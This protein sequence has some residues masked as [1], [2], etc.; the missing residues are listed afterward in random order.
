[1]LRRHVNQCRFRISRSLTWTPRAG[2]FVSHS[3]P[4]QARQS[5]PTVSIGTVT[6]QTLTIVPKLTKNEE[7]PIVVVAPKR[8]LLVDILKANLRQFSPE[9]RS[10]LRFQRGNLLPSPW[11]ARNLEQ[12]FEERLHLKWHMPFWQ[13]CLD[14]G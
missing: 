11:F 13:A 7:S 8:K 10:R 5:A 6:W 3:G 14:K 9:F 1:M 4:T 2:Y 12:F